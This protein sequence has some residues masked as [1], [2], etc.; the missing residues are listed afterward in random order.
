VKKQKNGKWIEMKDDKNG[1]ND[2]DLGEKNKKVEE[3][4]RDYKEE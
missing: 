1:K 2:S 4:Y 3:V